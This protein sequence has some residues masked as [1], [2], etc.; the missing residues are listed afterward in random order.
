MLPHPND[1]YS[2][3]SLFFKFIPERAALHFHAY[4]QCVPSPAPDGTNNKRPW[5]SSATAKPEVLPTNDGVTYQYL[6]LRH[7]R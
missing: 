2:L 1:F 3:P 5:K 7:P 4:A 6:T